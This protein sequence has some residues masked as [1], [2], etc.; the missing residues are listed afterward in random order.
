MVWEGVKGLGPHVEVLRGLCVVLGNGPISHKQAPSPL[1]YL[2]DSIIHFWFTLS[3]AWKQLPWG[4]VLAGLLMV[5]FMG[6]CLQN[7]GS[8]IQ[9]F[10]TT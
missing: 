2:A 8:G 3:S 10:H 7:Q 1:Y 6:P 4:S 9:S 5:V